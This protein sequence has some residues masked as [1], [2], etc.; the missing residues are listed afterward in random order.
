MYSPRR[1]AALSNRSFRDAVLLGRYPEDLIADA[2]SL[3]DWSFVADGDMKT[4]AAPI[5]LLGVNYYRPA[6]VAAKTPGAPAP[7]PDAA[8]G[9]PHGGWGG[10]RS[11]YPGCDDIVSMPG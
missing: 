5:D 9:T 11:P 7:T 8:T 6:R 1:V 3:T 10:S 2:R 4:I